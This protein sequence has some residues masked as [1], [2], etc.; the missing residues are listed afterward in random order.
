M[1]IRESFPRAVRQ[2]DNAWI[3]LSDGK[4]LGARI[5]LPEDAQRDPVPGI[6]EYLPYRKGDWMAVRDSLRHPYVAGHGY[7]CLRVDMRGS[8]DSEGVLFDEYLPQEQEDGVEAIAWIA[9]QPWCNGAVGIIGTSWGGFNGLQIAARRPPEL[10]AAISVFSTDDRYADDIHYMGGCLLTSKMLSWAAT[11]LAFNARPPDPAVV[12]ERWRELWLE[13]LEQTPPFVEAWL[14]HQR[15]D[16]YW[17]QGSVCED[18]SAIKCPIYLVGGWLDPYRD[19][20]FRLLEGLSCPRKALIGPWAHRSYPDEGVPGPAIGWLQEA[21]RWWDHWLKGIDTGIMDEPMLRAWMQDSAAPS[22]SCAVRPGRWIAEQSWPCPSVAPHAVRLDFDGESILGEQ[23]AG[24]D[25]G[26]WLPRAT[27]DL[28]PDQRGE[29]GLALAFTTAP[30][31]DTIEILGVCEVALTLSSDRPQALV[32]VRLCDVRPDGSS[33]LVSRGLLNLTHRESH[34]QPRPLVP[35]ERYTVTVRLGS[36]AHAFPA[37]HRV[38]VAVS[39]TYWL[40]AWPPP[41]SVTLTLFGGE[42]RLPARRHQPADDRLRPFEDPEFA[43]PI[44][45]E[46]LQHGAPVR[47]GAQVVRRDVSNGDVEVRTEFDYGAAGA[48]QGLFPGG[49]EYEES[50]ADTFAIAEG[51]PLS[52]EARSEWQIKIGRGT[53][54][55]RVETQSRLWSDAEAFYVTNTVEAYEG[56]EQIFMRVRDFSVPRDLV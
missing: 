18:Y 43:R 1:K 36:I 34:E 28:P 51:D 47:G 55:T 11:M 45:V 37:G 29:D 14:S 8:G 21:V 5:W 32:A 10:R 38:R 48:T 3:P 15:R 4:R 13:R 17:K 52:V 56:A 24:L 26:G 33:L 30:L 50:G 9:S 12:G 49:L 6:I 22:R 27:G 44:P 7:A 41:E 31:V 46:P 20:V 16:D 42:L 54:R 19:A 40:F 25:S 53:W 23:T 2:I 35:G 39:P